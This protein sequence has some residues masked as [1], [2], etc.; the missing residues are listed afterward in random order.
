M[1]RKLIMSIGMLVFMAAVVAG[2][3]GAFFSDTETSTGNTFTAG[4]IDLTVDS[5]A[6]YNGS[7]CTLGDWDD[8]ED[9]PMTGRWVGGDEYPVGLPCTGTWEATDLGAKTFFSYTDVKPGDEGENTISLHV[10]SNPAWACIDVSLT[11]N[12]DNGINEPESAVDQT[13]GAGNG[14]LAQNMK[15]AA[16]LDQG[17]YSGWQGKTEDPT[18]GDNKWAGRDSLEK[19]LF[20]NE[21]G[22]ASDVLGGKNYALAMPGLNGSA[23]LTPNQTNYIGLAWCAGTQTVGASSI[24]CDGSTL[25]NIVQT[26]LMEAT[27]AFRVEQSRNNPN[28]TCIP[29]PVPQP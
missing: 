5:E 26:D 10:T 1:N 4:A 14:E 19:L 8:E 9:T 7:I 3:T 20:S 27:I 22:P 25:G 11:K 12:D 16:W 21:S 18:E 28:F 13:D 24:T 6:H 17:A 2:G 29:R 23:P 15:F